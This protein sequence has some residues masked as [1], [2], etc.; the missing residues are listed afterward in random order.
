MSTQ[1]YLD[2][3]DTVL[4]IHG[5]VSFQN[6]T[7][8]YNQLKPFLVKPI[9]I[10]DCHGIGYADSTA[11]SLLLVIEKNCQRSEL[12]FINLSESIQSLV[13]LYELE[14]ILSP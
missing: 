7:D 5:D 3:K 13:K 8:L 9:A 12:K 1:A 4:S 14:G 10:V 6:V 2:Y 11:V